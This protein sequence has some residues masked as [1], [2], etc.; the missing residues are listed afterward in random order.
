MPI[1][2]GDII[3]IT[4]EVEKKWL[5]EQEAVMATYVN[6]FSDQGMNLSENNQKTLHMFFSPRR[7]PKGLTIENIQLCVS[8][9]YSREIHR[10]QHIP[11]PSPLSLKARITQKQFKTLICAFYIEC[12]AVIVHPPK[13]K[14]VRKHT[15]LKVLARK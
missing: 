2:R 4:E 8:L 9:A 13:K 15:P 5:A 6:M 3:S 14:R 12:A 10:T 7:V 11:L 1:K